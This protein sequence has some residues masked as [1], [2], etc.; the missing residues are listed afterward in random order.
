MSNLFLCICLRQMN[1]LI[2]MVLYSIM[3]DMIF[4]VVRQTIWTR[5]RTAQITIGISAVESPLD[6]L[7]PIFRSE[8]VR[9]T[10]SQLREIGI[11][12]EEIMR[13]MCNK[14]YLFVKFDLK[15]MGSLWQVFNTV[16]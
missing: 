8:R 5:K 2:V 14:A 7:L 12:D 10:E 9:R 16:S 4:L 15:R 1:K 6:L 3:T 13:S 11:E